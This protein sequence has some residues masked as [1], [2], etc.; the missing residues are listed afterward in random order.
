VVDTPQNIDYKKVKHENTTH[1]GNIRR[2][3]FNNYKA[4]ISVLG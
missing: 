1:F 4:R 2:T 3:M